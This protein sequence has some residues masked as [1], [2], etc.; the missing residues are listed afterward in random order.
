MQHLLHV[1]CYPNYI[2]ATNRNRTESDK[3]NP[4]YYY[5][6]DLNGKLDVIIFEKHDQ[7][8]KYIHCSKIIF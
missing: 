1:R 5:L 6:S 8:L 3:K 4:F 7:D 2:V